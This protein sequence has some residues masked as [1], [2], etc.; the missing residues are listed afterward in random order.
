M[1]ETSQDS[2]ENIRALQLAEIAKTVDEF[3][4]IAQELNGRSEIQ[5]A[6]AITLSQ[7]SGAMH[8]LGQGVGMI[9][10]ELSELKARM[11]FSEIA[12]RPE[13]SRIVTP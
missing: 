5:T 6:I 9:L 3:R 11:E 8:A 13:P 10:K 4:A 12:R 7:L 1:S 2:Q